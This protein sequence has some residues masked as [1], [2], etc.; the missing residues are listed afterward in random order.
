MGLAGTGAGAEVSA[1]DG[2]NVRMRV[3]ALEVEG[4]WAAGEQ[5]GE[6]GQE[7]V[8]GVA[9]GFQ[10]AHEGGD[11]GAEVVHVGDDTAGWWNWLVKMLRLHA[12]LALESRATNR[13]R[14]TP[15]EAG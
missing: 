14:R 6:L 3:P 9:H 8:A 15:W 2:E 4:V 7:E 5:E 1:D 11:L 12:S 10:G 13:E